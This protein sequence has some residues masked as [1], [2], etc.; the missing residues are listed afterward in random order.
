[1]K[2]IIT[3]LLVFAV[4]ELR[5]ASSARTIRRRT[6]Q[7]GFS[8]LRRHGPPIRRAS[9]IPASIHSTGSSTPSIQAIPPF[10]PLP[11]ARFPPSLQGARRSEVP[12]DFRPAKDVPLPPAAKEALSVGQA[13]MTEESHAR[14]RQRRPGALYLREPD[15]QHSFARHCG[16]A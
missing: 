10:L 14:S 4:A 7:F 2:H 6:R 13:W 1:M 16:S 15:C 9:Q 3:S 5:Q 8:G 11:A 12:K